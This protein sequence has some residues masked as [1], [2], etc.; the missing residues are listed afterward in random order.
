[1]QIQGCDTLGKDFAKRIMQR[2][3]GIEPTGKGYKNDGGV[4]VFSSIYV[5][6]TR[7]FNPKKQRCFFQSSP[8]I[9]LLIFLEREL[10]K[11]RE[12]EKQ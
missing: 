7:S 9:C 12:R 5:P 1:M 6:S 4:I 8:R 3:S 2:G 10:G 11:E